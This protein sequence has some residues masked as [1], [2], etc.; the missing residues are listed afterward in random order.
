MPKEQR[1][2]GVAAGGPLKKCRSERQAREEPGPALAEPRG[3]V[4][5]TL[6]LTLSLV[7]SPCGL[8]TRGAMWSDLH[9]RRSPVLC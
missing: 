6:A 4:A 8:L 9:F 1:G 3:A 5:E 2:V 7:H